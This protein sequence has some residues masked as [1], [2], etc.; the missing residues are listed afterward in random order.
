MAGQTQPGRSIPSH[1]HDQTRYR[2][3]RSLHGLAR[4]IDRNETIGRSVAWLSLG[5]VLVEFDV[6]VMRYVFGLGSV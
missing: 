1:T 4:A 6:V 5:L 2:K 3:V